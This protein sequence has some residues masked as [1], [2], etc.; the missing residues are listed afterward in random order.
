MRTAAG[1]FDVCHMGE[2]YL[3]GEH[4]LA[5]VDYLVTNDIKKANVGQAVY[6][7]C[8]NKEGTILDDLIVYKLGDENLLVVCNASNRDKISAHFKAA[9]KDHCEFRDASDEP[10]SSRSRVEGL[11]NP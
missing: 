11:R 8:L 5:V 1:L 4:A 10:R 3:T 9:A 2:L 7:V 6:T